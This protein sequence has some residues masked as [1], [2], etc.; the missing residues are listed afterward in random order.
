MAE[1]AAP[2]A[3]A[4]A[5]PSW[6]GSTE[7]IIKMLMQGA[8]PAAVADASAPVAANP[9]AQALGQGA[10]PHHSADATQIQTPAHA[11]DLMGTAAGRGKV[12]FAVPTLQAGPGT[13]IPI[14]ALLQAAQQQEQLAPH[15]EAAKQR[16]LQAL[17]ARQPRVMPAQHA[18]A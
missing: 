12:P 14:A 9:W 7:N 1:E 10:A 2:V 15:V 3:A 4:L 6:A 16:L 11:S 18:K 5:P 17:L 13:Q 8:Q